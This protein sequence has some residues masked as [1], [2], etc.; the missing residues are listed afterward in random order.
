MTRLKIL[1]QPNVKVC[2]G[3]ITEFVEDESNIVGRRNVPCSN[4]E[5][6]KYMKSRCAFNHMSVALRRTKVL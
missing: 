1:E 4:D 6:Y 3:Q 5:I 2:G